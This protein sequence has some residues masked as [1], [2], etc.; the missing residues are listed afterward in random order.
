M[1]KRK[2]IISIS[3]IRGLVGENLTPKETYVASNCF[4]QIYLKDRSK[5]LRVVVGRDPK[6]S[7]EELLKGVI[8]SLKRNGVGE[9]KFLGIATLP[10]MEWAVKYYQASGGIFITA[11]HNP[12]EWNG[13]KLIS[14]YEEGAYLLDA[15][16]MASID[17]GWEEESKQVGEVSL[18][19]LPPPIDY[20]K[21]YNQKVQ[22]VVKEV[23][24]QCQ[25][26]PGR[27]EELFKKIRE[28][29]PKIVLD[30]C[31][32]EGVSIPESFL[33]DLGIESRNI[34]KINDLPI[35]ECK[36]R[37]EPAPPYL[38]GL[39]EAIEKQGADIGF[40]FDP[41]QD[42]LAVMPLNSEEN[43][44]ALA[45]KFLLELQKESGRKYLKAIPV[46]LSTSSVWDDLAEEYGVKIIRTPVGEINV[47]KAMEKVNSPFGA[48]G[49]GG[50]ILRE[51]N[52]GRNSTVGMVLLLAYM[53]WKSAE[54]KD[55][56]SELTPYFLLKE[57][58][59]FS[60]RKEE[61]S[62]FL[63]ERISS[64][65]Q[66]N[67]GR[68]EYIDR[69]DGYKL[70]Y[71]DNSWVHLRPSNTEPVVRIFAEAK[72]SPKSQMLINEVK[73]LLG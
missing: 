29:Q 58:I 31:C 18:P 52:Y 57:K 33:L 32:R 17:A 68:I 64:F 3:G 4:Q 21:A 28:R 56:E 34:V 59:A 8:A 19:E 16:K 20:L 48:E 6:P 61:I 23:I 60:L 70:I 9:V 65:I 24:D 15:K 22:E 41:D 25:E 66:Q 13:V 40:A 30:A 46:N 26:I 71:R 55:L 44:P 45:G 35:S 10:I 62:A 36:R 67:E 39:R 7:G 38:T 14:S 37:L 47:V 11:S 53:A 43:T 5:P 2:L 42:R 12:L 73:S 49:N 51:V 27:G 72:D 54:I 50:I 69:Q 63:Q 1:K